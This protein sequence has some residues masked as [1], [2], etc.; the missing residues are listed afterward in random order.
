M[1]PNP[2]E[3]EPELLEDA[4]NQW[5]IPSLTQDRH[6]RSGTSNH[7]GTIES[8]KN[9]KDQRKP[10]LEGIWVSTREKAVQTTEVAPQQ[11]SNPKAHKFTLKKQLVLSLGQESQDEL[12]IL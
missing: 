10:G 2:Y 1:T 3:K 4:L 12:N 11:Y 5:L 8:T 7:P 6:K 9:N